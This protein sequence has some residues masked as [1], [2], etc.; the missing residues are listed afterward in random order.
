MAK[1]IHGDV[2][3]RRQQRVVGI[4]TSD[5]RAEHDGLVGLVLEVAVPELVKL[6]THLLELFL[7]GT[8][9][10]M[11]SQQGRNTE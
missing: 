8:N 10:Y 11:T 5:D 4:G 1:N 6:R 9:L 3:A 7:G 2:L